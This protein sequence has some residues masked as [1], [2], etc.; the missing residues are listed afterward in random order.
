MAAW[1]KL[2]RVL[3]H[4][5]MNSL[6][7][8]TSLASTAHTMVADLVVQHPDDTC[9]RE[10]NK[11]RNAAGIIEKRGQGLLNF[12]NSY[13]KL[14]RVP[15][16]VFQE[17]A[18]TTLFARIRQLFTR[19]LEEHGMTFILRCEPDNLSV[20]ADEGLIEQVL[21]NL[22]DNALAAVEQ[23]SEPRIGLAA[24]VDQRG[25][26][27]IAVAD[28][29]PGITAEA[30]T[31]IFVPFFTTRK[32]GTGIGL[33]LSREIMR[34]HGGSITVSSEPHVRTVFSLHFV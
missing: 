30:Q 23:A 31:K 15:T 34:L 22:V 1:Q 11:I 6:T 14:T 18:L 10:L 24:N 21:L 16:P 32:H 28:N 25:K 26:V 5:I 33:S 13:R 19:Q 9:G 12:V 3:N 17:V 4:E 7:P 20:R 27:V 29:G 2:I 8:I